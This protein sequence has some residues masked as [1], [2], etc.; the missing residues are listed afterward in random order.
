[1]Y[2]IWFMS[3][4]FHLLTSSYDWEGNFEDLKVCWLETYRSKDDYKRLLRSCGIPY[5]KRHSFSLTFHPKS[6]IPVQKIFKLKEPS[7]FIQWDICFTLVS[8]CGGC[9]QGAQPVNG[10]LEQM[11]WQS[12]GKW[13]S[14]C[15]PLPVTDLC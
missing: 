6:D 13:S 2:V 5:R 11:E 4:C 10:C 1:M 14:C 12:H 8:R 3:V 15:T 7:G 9:G